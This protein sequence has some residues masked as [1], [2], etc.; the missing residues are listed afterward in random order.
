MRVDMGNQ[1]GQMV[2]GLVCVIVCNW[3]IGR[4]WCT[5]SAYKPNSFWSYI[6]TGKITAI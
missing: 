6:L 2:T 3:T 4:R 1:L 5:L